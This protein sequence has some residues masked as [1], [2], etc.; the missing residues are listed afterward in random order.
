MQIL[1]S[2]VH[3][4]IE[5]LR[6][7]ANTRTYVSRHL[8]T[9]I[10]NLLLAA[11]HHSH[12]E[13]TLL[14]ARCTHD[15][16]DFI[17]SACILFNL[18]LTSPDFPRHDKTGKNA[19]ALQTEPYAFS[20]GNSAQHSA[21]MSP[22][23]YSCTEKDVGRVFAGVLAHRLA[24]CSPIEGPLRSIFFTAVDVLDPSGDAKAVQHEE[25]AISVFS[26]LAGIL[27]SV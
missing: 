9:Y 19:T 18:P 23:V 22:A 12:L 21:N 20:R 24:T 6:S 2:I 13:G 17:C 14:S 25:D 7:L 1:P 8:D 15:M 10:M 4:D 26:I 3:Q 11:R 16:E 5:E 27:Q